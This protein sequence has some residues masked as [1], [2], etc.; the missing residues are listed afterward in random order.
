MYECCRRK[1]FSI[2]RVS[3]GEKLKKIIKEVKFEGAL[4]SL[5]LSQL[6]NQNWLLCVSDSFTVQDI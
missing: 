4:V 2:L 3:R 1:V 5:P 6:L